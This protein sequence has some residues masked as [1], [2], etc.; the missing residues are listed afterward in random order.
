MLNVL[1]LLLMPSEFTIVSSVLLWH[2][3]APNIRLPLPL[4]QAY[5]RAGC[6]KVRG[7]QC[8]GS[9]ASSRSCPMPGL[10][11]RGFEHTG[12]ATNVKVYDSVSHWSWCWV[13]LAIWPCDSSIEEQGAF[14]MCWNVV[15]GLNYGVHGSERVAI[16]RFTF[17][18]ISFHWRLSQNLT[19]PPCS[20]HHELKTQGGGSVSRQCIPGRQTQQ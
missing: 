7:V 20:E 3:E 15:H 13:A 1:D 16:E 12:S 5:D 18:N 17:T 9:A 8:C 2:Y 19:L 10:G 11:I 4:S 14:V 6:L